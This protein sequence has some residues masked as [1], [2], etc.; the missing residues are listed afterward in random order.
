[1]N[2]NSKDNDNNNSSNNKEEEEDDTYADDDFDTPTE[3]DMITHIS[4]KVSSFTASS[5]KEREDNDDDY[6]DED[7]DVEITRSPP[8]R[9]SSGNPPSSSSSSSSTTGNLPSTNAA[10]IEKS[11]LSSLNNVSSSSSSSSSSPTVCPAIT[12][13][14]YYST[15]Q[16]N[17]A[18]PEDIEIGKQLG[19]GGFAVV[20]E[21][22]YKS[23]KYAVKQ[24][25]DP[26]ISEE[27][28]QIFMQEAMSQGRL[29]H[30]HIV[31]LIA[32]CS[33][34]PRQGYIMELC[35]PSLFDI[36]HNRRQVYVP[37]HQ[38]IRWLKETAGALTFLHAQKP[39]II[40]RDIKSQNVIVA[41]PG[42]KSCKLTDFGLVS[43]RVT[44]AGT[45][46]YMAP[47]LLSNKAFNRSVDVYAFG[48]LL[49]ECLS[50][51]IPYAGWRLIDI[52][53]AVLAGKRLDVQCIDTYQYQQYE[54]YSLQKKQQ[55][56]GSSGSSSSPLVIT[57]PS[58]YKDILQ[59]CKQLIQQCGSIDNQNRPTMEDIYY[60]LEEWEKR[61]GT[62]Q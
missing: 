55:P 10:V 12:M 28:R 29:S 11:L 25:V 37:L 19:G 53:E 35:G 23:K 45:P 49:W 43:T 2:S 39:S 41:G 46:A 27:D 17:E 14:T 1:M 50:R 47:E 8:N 40:H 36:L 54:K 48:I 56:N 61:L 30:P 31:S 38:T 58:M 6:Y 32:V 18:L 16:W 59:G 3:E 20:F 15:P 33:K 24:I 62:V 22:I 44:T 42:G 52:K 4:N 21:C 9:S 5:S 34:P 60:R 57:V 51:E 13:G 26:S 7:F